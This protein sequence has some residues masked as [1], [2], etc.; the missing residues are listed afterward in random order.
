MCVDVLRYARASD[1]YINKVSAFVFPKRE[2]VSTVVLVEVLFNDFQFFYNLKRLPSMEEIKSSFMNIFN[3][4]CIT[5]GKPIEY[6]NTLFSIK[7]SEAE[8]QLFGNSAI[9]LPSAR[10]LVV[11][12]GD[13]ILK[14]HQH[15]SEDFMNLISK[16]AKQPLRL[17][18]NIPNEQKRINRAFF[19]VTPK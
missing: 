19:S 16:F 6:K 15:T 17:L 2:V 5:V 13:E 9:E 10:A 14:R 12:C 8:L 18:I 11:A 7:L 3:N 4:Q 1:S